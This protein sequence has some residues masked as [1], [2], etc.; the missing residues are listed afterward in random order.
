MRHFVMVAAVLAA[1]G[2]AANAA[3]E[4]DKKDPLVLAWSDDGRSLLLETRV[5]RPNL[6]VETAFRI[7]SLNQAD[8]FKVRPSIRRPGVDEAQPDV[9][10]VKSCLKEMDALGA[11]LKRLNF[12]GVSVRALE[13][14]KKERT[15]FLRVDGQKPEHLQL[16]AGG[17][18][19]EI[20]GLAITLADEKLGIRQDGGKPLEHSGLGHIV[21]LSVYVSPSKELLL[22]VGLDDRNRWR[23]LSSLCRNKSEGE[24]WRR[25]SHKKDLVLA[26]SD[27]GRSV[28][29]DTGVI[30]PNSA[31]TTI[32][33]VISVNQADWFKVRPSIRNLGEDEAQPDLISKKDCAEK[34]VAL[35][36]DLKRLNFSGVWVNTKVCKQKKRT[37]F[38]LAHHGQKPEH[39]QPKAEGAT[40]ELEGLTLTLADEKLVIKQDG[41]KPLEHF[42][43]GHIVSLSVYVSPSKELLLVVGFD[44]MNRWSI[45]S[46][47]CRNK[48]EGEEW[49]RI[50]HKKSN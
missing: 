21:S 33:R 48:S 46:C 35:K 19:L 45:L 22:V 14:R 36:A 8:W 13:C 4:G 40:L 38:L 47:L 9:V 25:I 16:K 50:S 31:V 15:R 29:L 42:G 27:D 24:E 7:I 3:A 17:P 37:R 6:T 2:P 26:W 20:E 1:L 12:G 32:F 18:T 5:T 44:D 43:L 28:L 49:R 34:M 41:S 23:V 30:R 39:L 11:A 10:S